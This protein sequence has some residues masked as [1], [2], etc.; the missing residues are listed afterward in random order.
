[1]THMKIFLSFTCGGLWMCMTSYA[2]HG[3]RW[4]VAKSSRRWM[5]VIIE[6]ERDTCGELEP[7]KGAELL[8]VILYHKPAI[9][10]H[11]RCTQ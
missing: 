7:W 3:T 11:S 2:D 1:M 10:Y 8:D 9:R 4:F 5:V 6:C